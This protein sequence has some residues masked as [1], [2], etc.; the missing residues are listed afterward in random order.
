MCFF[1]AYQW[2][3]VVEI[4]QSNREVTSG[5]SNVGR[6]VTAPTTMY[7]GEAWCDST[8]SVVTLRWYAEQSRYTTCIGA[9]FQ[10][11]TV[12]LLGRH[13]L[14]STLLHHPLHFNIISLLSYNYLQV[15]LL[16][17][18]SFIPPLLSRKSLASFTLVAK[19][20]DPPLSGWLAII[21]FLC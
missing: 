6:Y 20:D 16:I 12:M 17:Y 1:A 13:T 11:C 21:N 4:D 5:S 7:Y 18:L 10:C 8:T 19:Y 3:R 15:L 14:Y 9:L 2:T